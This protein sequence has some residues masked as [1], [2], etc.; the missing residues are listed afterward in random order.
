MTD[1]FLNTVSVWVSVIPVRIQF[2]V[3]QWGI[4]HVGL[5]DNTCCLF[6]WQKHVMTAHLQFLFEPEILSGTTESVKPWGAWL[7]RHLLMSSRWPNLMKWYTRTQD[8]QFL[9]KMA[10]LWAYQLTIQ[11]CNCLIVQT[12]DKEI[13]L[14]D[15]R[16]D[17]TDCSIKCQAFRCE[18]KTILFSSR[19]CSHYP[20]LLTSQSAWCPRLFQMQ[21]PHSSSR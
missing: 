5:C 14:K 7:Q 12:R 20:W 15:H 3:R 1:L 2:E 16:V 18:S 17:E 8:I 6:K 4:P 9:N 10:I 13:K 19:T 11:N 21:A